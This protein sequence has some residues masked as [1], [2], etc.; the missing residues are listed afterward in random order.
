M[1][2]STEGGGVVFGAGWRADRARQ[3]AACLPSGEVTVSC[4]A[5]FG[6]GGLGRHLQEIV[7]A[8]RRGGTGASCICGPGGPGAE[9]SG[10][11]AVAPGAGASAAVRALRRSPAWR[12]W[13]SNASFDG[14]AA[15]QLDG[16][17]HLIAFSGQA[18]T[19]FGRARR[20]AAGSCSLVSPTSH[21]SGV[22]R[23]YREA[24]SRYPLEQSWTPRLL[25]RSLDEYRAADRIYVSSRYVWESFVEQGVPE[26]RLALFPLTPDEGFTPA[27]APNE[28]GLFEILYVGSLSVVK[29]VPL[30]LDAFARQPA[31]ELRLILLGGWESRGMRRHI[32]AA[33]AADPRIE[34]RPGRPLEHLRTARLFVHPSYEDGFSYS[35][36]EA[37]ACGVPVI[38][39]ENTGAKEL[40][41]SGRTGVIAP[42][43]DLDWLTEALAAA[44]RG[45]LLH[46]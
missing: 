7:E 21:L 33:C 19:Q 29:G 22:D 14:A 20:D 40:I 2:A 16:G 6:S 27:T 43:G 3:Q 30:L 9:G 13:A 12:I 28:S 1:T 18:R 41:D 10:C 39:T 23:R 5:P 11:R 15:R 34:V 42:T 45:E 44:H 46:D 4:S 38:A 25:R 32:E 31:D 24:V 37:L 8:L 36:A 26:E 35:C 17:G